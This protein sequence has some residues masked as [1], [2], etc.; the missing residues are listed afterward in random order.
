VELRQFE[1]HLSRKIKFAVYQFDVPS[2]NFPSRAEDTK[3]TLRI[4][5]DLTEVQTGHLSNTSFHLSHL[6]LP[7][8]A[9]VLDAWIRA[10]YIK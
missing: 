2:H 8:I 9:R 5:S 1:N 4:A 7:N 10:E 3:K 6:V